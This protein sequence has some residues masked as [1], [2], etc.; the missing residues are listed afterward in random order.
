M[1]L[2]LYFCYLSLQALDISCILWNAILYVIGLTEPPLLLVIF[3]IKYVYHTWK[4]SASWQLFV[5]V[6]AQIATKN[7]QKND[8][9][10]KS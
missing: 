7:T 2:F 10:C 4:K 9:K 8:A 1:I 5:Y 3:P 6:S